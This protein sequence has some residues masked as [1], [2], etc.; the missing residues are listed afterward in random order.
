MQN[1]Y[2]PPITMRAPIYGKDAIEVMPEGM[3]GYRIETIYGYYDEPLIYTISNGI[4]TYFAYWMG[5]ADEHIHMMSYQPLSRE[6]QQD[7]ENGSLC[8]GG[9]LVSKPS[10]IV[11]YDRSRKGTPIV[12]IERDVDLS[13]KETPKK[14]TALTVFDVN[15][16]PGKVAVYYA[17]DSQLSLSQQAVLLARAISLLF[18]SGFDSDGVLR[19]ELY[20]RYNTWFNTNFSY[21]GNNVVPTLNFELIPLPNNSSVLSAKRAHE[22]NSSLESA[23]VAF[24]GQSAAV[25]TIRSINKHPMIAG[26]SL[27]CEPPSDDGFESEQD[28][29]SLPMMVLNEM[30]KYHKTLEKVF[31]EGTDAFSY[32]RKR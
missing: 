19:G 22:D 6:E 32:R 20:E 18:D 28:D 1:K 5:N 3:E 27:A 11:H 14:G 16:L 10:M 24:R 2:V 30:E 23:Y 4:D 25:A 21:D 13:E 15:Q 26:R 31:D 12:H 8:L 29:L 9:F 7:I 17:E